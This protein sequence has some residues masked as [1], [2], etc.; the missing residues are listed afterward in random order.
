M[1]TSKRHAAAW[2]AVLFLFIFWLSRTHN[3]LTL[4]TFLDEASHLTRAQW[5]WQGRPFYLLETGKALAPYLAALFWP[6]TAPVFIGRYVVV[7]LGAIGLA[8]VYAVGRELHSRQ[9]GLLA[10]TLWIFA[11]ELMFFE[12]MA[13]VDTTTSSMAMLTLWIAIRMIRSGR[14]RTAILCGV[15]LMLCVL[16]KTTGLIFFAIPLLAAVL[17]TARTGWRRRARQAV[18]AYLVVGVLL[19][20][21]VLY[22]L[23]V[24][25]DP[26]GITNGV[27]STESKSLRMR[28]EEHA[29]KLWDAE[30]TYY[31]TP[32]IWVILLG[33]AVA[34]LFRPRRALLLL[35]PVVAL[36]AAI[37]VGASSLWLRYASPAAPSMLLLTAIGLLT[38]T[39]GLRR[40][41]FPRIVHTLPWLI[42]GA[43]AI[44]VGIP[45]HL[46]AYTDPSQLP[47]PKGDVE[48]YIQWIPSGY[49]IRD[50][51]VY[52][53]QTFDTQPII[54]IGTAVNCNGARLYMPPDAS[55][56]FICPDL[57]WAGGNWNVI[58]MIREQADEHRQ[59][60]VLGEDIAIVPEYYLPR[61]H[62]ILK[63]FPRPGKQYTVRLYRVDRSTDDSAVPDD[64]PAPVPVQDRHVQSNIRGP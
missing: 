15:G 38:I 43:W 26:I 41:R 36:L 58:Q 61:P 37:V 48:E 47:L 11:P 35:L 51:A 27:V 62:V 14:A 59:V 31:S 16:S 25:A 54:V 45:F 24:S 6:F 56:H 20:G 46:T 4:P 1:G 40:L 13:L 64:A 9:A 50:A 21:P 49:G 63:E 5:V 34:V 12:R 52:L 19:A 30:N 18:V 17:V 57:D 55:I 29:S 8:S 7:L 28:I 60:Y 42:T 2:V 10:M 44:G 23:S 53:H 3:L 22:I 33:C 32:M 39:A